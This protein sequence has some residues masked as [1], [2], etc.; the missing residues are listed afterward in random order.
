M[1][2]CNDSNDNSIVIDFSLFPFCFRTTS[3]GKYTNHLKDDNQFHE[4]F[5]RLI[6][7]DIP[8]ISQFTFDTVTR[9]TQKHSHVISTRDKQ[10]QLVISILKEIFKS[11]YNSENLEKDF[12]LFLENNINDYAIWQLG[13][14]GGIR[15]IGIKKVN[16]FYVLFIDYHHL[17]YPD[18]NYNQPNYQMYNYCPMINNRKGG[19]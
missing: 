12:E 3:I 1:T 4:F 9:E 14:S 6:E 13:I 11:Y 5:Q 7:K 17:I 8:A 16:R 18:K 10:Y 15:L 2:T 19:N